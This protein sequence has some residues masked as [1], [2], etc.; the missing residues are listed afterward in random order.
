MS[1]ELEK[2]VGALLTEINTIVDRKVEEKLPEMIRALGIR[3]IGVDQ[4]S[5]INPVDDRVQLVDAVEVARMLGEDVS[6]PAAINRAKKHVYNLA[7]K[8]LIPSVRV[9]PRCVRF[10]L[11]KVR[12][13]IAKGGKARPFTQAA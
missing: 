4:D 1:A 5:E 12:E 2:I 11:A 13:V 9:S 8:E 3:S 10:D 6:T 7:R